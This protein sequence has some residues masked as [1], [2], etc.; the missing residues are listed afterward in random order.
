M[1]EKVKQIH[2]AFNDIKEM[3]AAVKLC[4]ENGYQLHH[5]LGNPNIVWEGIKAFVVDTEDK[6]VFRTN[7]TCMSCWCNGARKPLYCFEFIENFVALAINR[8]LKKYNEL[9]AL[10][11]KDKSRP[12]GGIYKIQ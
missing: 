8:D 4:Q 7:V 3:K 2:L 10:A 5:G 1:K 12:I 9:L 11:K 6:T